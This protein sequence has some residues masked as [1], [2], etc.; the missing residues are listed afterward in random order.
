MDF[1]TNVTP[2]GDFL[3]IRGFQNGERFSERIKYQP[4]L[5][6]PFKGQC[7]HNSLDG[8]GLMPKSYNTIREARSA[9]KRY[10]EHKNFVYGTD[11]FQYQFISDKYSG[12]VEYDK[13]K[14]RIYT[15]DIEVESE[16]GFPNVEDHAE[17]MICI[18]IKDQVKKQILVWG[19]ADYKPKQDNVHYIKCIDEKDLLIKFIKFWKEYTPDI[20]TGWNS[21]YF[22]IPYLVRRID[23]ILGETVKN[24]MSPWGQVM[25]DSTYYMGKTQTYF[26]LHGIAQ[27]D[28]L[29]LYQK[30]TIKN[31]ESYK[32]DHIG[33]VE[34]GETKDDNP[35]DTFKEW[36][37]QDI[38]SF[39]DYNIQDVELVD[40][41]EDRLQLI[42]LAITM[43]YNAKVNYEDVFS[44]VRMWD[45]IIYNELLKTNT[46]V[47]MRDMNPQSKELV[48]AYVKEPITGFHD[49]V[50]SFDLNS[51]YP[52]LIMQYN[53][54]P[55]TILSDRK[56]VLIDELLDKKIDMS[57]GNCM[58]ANGTMYK[59]NKLGMLPRI[60]K[61]EYD[62]R[63]IYKKKMLEA[64]QMYANTKDKKYEKL[65]RKFYLIQHSKKISLNSAYGAIGNKYFRYYD[66]R[67]AEAIT[68]S[69][70]L[71]I[72]WIDKKVNEYFNKLYKTDNKDY[73]IASDTD[74][75][76]VNMAPL[77]KLTGATD[78]TKIVKAL[79]QF[80]TEK[81]E[82]Y[83]EKCYN[84]LGSYMNVYENKMVM[85]REVIADKGIW[86]AK[87]RYILNV[88]N[89]EGVQYPEPKLKIMGIEAVKT[90]TPLPC[91]DK[92]KEAFK[93]IMGGDQQEMK[94]FIINF[95]REFELLP[96]EQI[97][98]PRSVN[99][100]KKYGDRTSIYK[101]G[102]PMHV[103]GALMYNHLL[104][105]KKIGH[106]FQPIYEGDK[107]K[108]IHLRKNLWN[109]NCITFISK[110]PKEFDMHG[111]IDY[112]TQF[113]KS[114]ME[115]LRFILGAINW[116]IDASDSNTIED[117]FA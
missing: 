52:H 11:R 92:L 110:L 74:S 36:Y 114:F 88:H 46:I 48:G 30:F 20:I 71:N 51:L 108:Y 66:H 2:H 61:R 70:Q 32:L 15:I 85:K 103:K 107:G 31:Q 41:L 60:I 112:E 64:E 73:V 86:T 94:Q 24:K 40:R 55:E 81:F 116:H 82:P 44:Q 45:T 9:I 67:Q 105:I 104:K 91:R 12:T 17:K 13:D 6:F 102:T 29:Q 42:E 38:Q 75:I 109:A 72:R 90:S 100:V 113:T 50:V 4:R 22:D 21:K 3:H 87:K 53:I 59:T 89:S 5:Y 77:V 19:L 93:V 78:K 49:W 79:D 10:E 98:F 117:F 34:L 27:L 80:C 43:A 26:R 62:D 33:F 65:A 101:K 84:E 8:K 83:I 56:D 96:P 28:Y 69:G 47:P 99:G 76:Y 23:K 68:T 58:A 39:I 97:A 25:E 16:H 35:Y 63:V 95:R 115:P 106:K 14:L 111:Y 18:T 37:Q 1:Y 54:S 7:T 57:D